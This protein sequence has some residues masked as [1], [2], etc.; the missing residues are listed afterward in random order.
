MK[1][2]A[3]AM[4]KQVDRVIG[5]LAR[6]MAQ[7]RHGAGNPICVGIVGVNHASRYRSFEG[8]RTWETDGRKDRHPVDEAPV[9]TRRLLAEAKPGLDEFIILPFRATNYEPYPFEWVDE[10]G[11]EEDYSAALVR[12]SREYDERFAR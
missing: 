11:T 10:E 5:D 6:Q 8:P 2:V 4:I 1:I 3:K 9:A 7:F 12:I